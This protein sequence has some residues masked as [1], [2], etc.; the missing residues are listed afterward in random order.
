MQ[1]TIGVYIPNTAADNVHNQS[2]IQQDISR[3]NIISDIQTK[4]ASMV[5]DISNILQNN[6]EANKEKIITFSGTNN[7]QE[8]NWEEF[9]IPPKFFCLQAEFGEIGY[10]L[11]IFCKTNIANE[12]C[13]IDSIQ[14]NDNNTFA[15]VYQYCGKYLYMKVTS[16]T[17]R[18]EDNHRPR[19][20]GI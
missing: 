12:W 14:S 5:I 15:K 17:F 3:N 1:Y 2:I 11:E 13:L 4:I 20:V 10:Q 8:G 9:S 16:Q 19:A 18:N 6:I 7:S